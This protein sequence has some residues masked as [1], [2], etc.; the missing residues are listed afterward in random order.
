MDSP[1][2]STSSSHREFP[3]TS[4]VVTWPPPGLTQRSELIAC[5]AE[6]LIC[7]GACSFEGYVSVM[8]NNPNQY[9]C[10]AFAGTPES[11]KLECHGSSSPTDI[12]QWMTLTIEDFPGT[13][14]P[15]DTV[16]QPSMLMCF[17]DTPGTITMN[18]WVGLFNLN[19]RSETSVKSTVEPREID[20][21]SI[22]DRIRAIQQGLES[23]W[24]ARCDFLYT[25][26]LYDAEFCSKPKHNI[27]EQIADLIMVLDHERWTDFSQLGNQVISGFFKTP[28]PQ[29][30]RA[31]FHQLL[32]GVELY[33]RLRCDHCSKD[34]RRS[35]LLRVPRKVAWDIALARRWLENI[36]L[37]LCQPDGGFRFVLCSKQRQVEALREFAWMLKWPNMAEVEYV[38]EEKDSEEIPLEDR[39]PLSMSW[40]SGTILPGSSA[41][42]L[43]MNTLIAC[44]RG[45]GGLLNGL[46]Y[47]FPN[48][49]FQY[50]ASTY[51]YADCIVAKVMG[52]GRGVNQV[53]G[54]T[55]PCLYTPDLDRIQCI[56]VRQQVSIVRHLSKRDIKSMQLRSDPLGPA[57]DYYPVEDYTLV[58]PDT[59][60]VDFARVEKLSFLLWSEPKRSTDNEPLT[61]NA[62]VTFAIDGD[63]WPL[64]LRYNV[65]FIEAAPCHSGPHV[66]FYDYIHQ[67]IRV[68]QLLDQRRWGRVAADTGISFSREGNGSFD[69]SNGRSCAGGREDEAVLVVEAFGHPDNEVFSRAWCAHMGLSAVVA[70][71]NDTCMACGIRGAY[72]ACV[73][74][75]IFTDGSRN[76]D[77]EE[78]DRRPCTKRGR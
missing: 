65:S 17:G 28:D 35:V 67:V 6:V 7:T 52:A 16:E 50:R 60:A 55:G 77:V 68:D 75:L 57:E 42:W 61:Y 44:D 24:Q 70:N 34:V 29:A 8:R 14:H 4:E 74:V 22:L 1:T 27:E 47:M 31:F 19:T 59:K 48:S 9:R 30:A 33:L 53:A 38:L 37:E 5:D 20:L 69:S 21:H 62:A 54:W 58:L 78:V 10:Y 51:F 18:Q 15:W 73:T 46:G 63:S 56:R 25:H 72:A 36:T 43:A 45:T 13:V 76:E 3:S 40:V 41:A 12:T 2:D 39:G 66:L 11:E 49:G 32:L 23:D 26:L 64:R 71:I